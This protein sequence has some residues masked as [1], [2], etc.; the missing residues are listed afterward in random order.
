MKINGSD[1]MVF[2]TVGGKLK[3]IAYATNHV[4][5]TQ[6]NTKDTSTKDDGNGMWQNFE[7]GLM[8]WTMQ[9]DNLMSDAAEN[10]ASVND[11]FDIYLKREPIEVAFSLQTNNP[12]YSKKLD[13]PF[14]APDGGWTPDT[15][16]Q[17]HGQ[18]LI[19]SINVTAQNGEKATCSV[20]FTGC[21]NLQKMGAGIQAAS[22][23]ALSAKS[24]VAVETATV[25]K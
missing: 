18:A 11:L 8:S 1:L 24:P 13:E 9:T 3:S 25:K 23:V 20:T 16:N 21:G 22:T 7:A 15:K 10:G 17:Y 12:D 6:M 14:V 5:D 2:A 19:T 4:L